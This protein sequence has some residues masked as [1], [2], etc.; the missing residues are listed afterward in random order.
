M[1]DDSG[2]PLGDLQLPVKLHLLPLMENPPPPPIPLSETSCISKT[3]ALLSWKKTLA[4]RRGLPH[5]TSKASAA[6]K[7]QARGALS[8]FTAP[9]L[10]DCGPPPLL[11]ASTLFI[12]F[13]CLAV[14][15]LKCAIYSAAKCLS[16]HVMP[17]ISEPSSF[18]AWKYLKNL[19]DEWV[20]WGH[21]KHQP[22]LKDLFYMTIVFEWHHWT[23]KGVSRGWL[24]GHL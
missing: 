24:N 14:G 3:A 15:D 2:G 23:S 20:L 4:T 17:R 8:I 5:K 11:A 6:M 19:R 1:A 10:S 9:L 12:H 22:E 7:T 16:Y 21:S 13:S 18:M